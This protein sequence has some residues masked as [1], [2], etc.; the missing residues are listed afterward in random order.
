MDQ[1]QAQRVATSVSLLGMIAKLVCARKRPGTIDHGAS[2]SGRL[3]N[4][5]V[6]TILSAATE[7]CCTSMWAT[8]AI[9]CSGSRGRD[10]G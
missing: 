7:G 6:A 4:H 9:C 2:V 8:E 3:V 1:L 10:R 5:H